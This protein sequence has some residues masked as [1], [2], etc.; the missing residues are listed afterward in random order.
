[1]EYIAKDDQTVITDADLDNDYRIDN[2]NKKS[3]KRETNNNAKKSNPSLAVLCL[4][5][6][7]QNIAE[8]MSAEQSKTFFG[9]IM[10]RSSDINDFDRTSL[11]KSMADIKSF[12]FAQRAT[13]MEEILK[14]INKGDKLPQLKDLNHIL[15]AYFTEPSIFA[16]K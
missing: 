10:R 1:M 13:I 15:L 16:N 2:T 6:I 14:S 9:Y 11:L 4:K 3:F 7:S 5:L 12:T 8:A